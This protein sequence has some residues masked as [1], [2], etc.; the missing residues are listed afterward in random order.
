M[1]K[2]SGH[3]STRLIIKGCELGFIAGILTALV[4]GFIMLF[5]SVYVSFS[6]PFFLIVANC[7]FWIIVGGLCG[8]VFWLC[9]RKKSIQGKE[10]GY[11]VLFFLLPFAVIYGYLGQ[12]YIPMKVWWPVW[13]TPVFDHHLSFL[14]VFILLAFIFFYFKK[15]GDKKE[16]PSIFFSL[17][18]IVIISIFQICSNLH[19][20]PYFRSFIK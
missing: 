5:P 18:I 3:S 19:C 14:W 6:Y 12:L 16:L 8:L 11:W 10:N 7:L 2:E 17:E 15:W 4:D 13:G 1:H 20:L 9:V